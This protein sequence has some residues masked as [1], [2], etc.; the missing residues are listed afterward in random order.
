MAE[1]VASR[2]DQSRTRT[3]SR[4]WGWNDAHR[5]WLSSSKWVAGWACRTLQV[6]V[7]RQYE[8]CTS[9]RTSV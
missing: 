4:I 1:M 2:D 7:Y 9:S 8:A 3:Y 6:V 5:R